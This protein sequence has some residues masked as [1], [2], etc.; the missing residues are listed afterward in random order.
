MFYAFLHTIDED[1]YTYPYSF[2]MHLTAGVIH[3]VDVLFQDG[4]D[5]NVSVQIYQGNFQLWPSNRGSWMK[6]NAT[7]VSFREFYHLDPGESLLTAKIAL[8]T[9]QADAKD[10]VIQLGVLPKKIIQPMSFDALLE[11]AMGFK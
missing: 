8:T 9:G 2:D 4:C 3:Q 6:G 10:V 7:V 5:H 11:A 1:T